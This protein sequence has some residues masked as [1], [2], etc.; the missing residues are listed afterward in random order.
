SHRNTLLACYIRKPV[1]KLTTFSLS[2]K[3]NPV[4]CQV[5]WLSCQNVCLFSDQTIRHKM[6]LNKHYSAAIAAYIIWGFFPI[7]LRWIQSYPAGD[8]LFYRIFLSLL[9]LVI[10]IALF[11]RKALKGDWQYFRQLTKTHRRQ[12]ILLT[13]AGAALLSVNWLL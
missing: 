1:P 6:K 12:A 11:R 3:A 10:V 4:P 8:I 13:L 9:T 5:N 7:P 2:K